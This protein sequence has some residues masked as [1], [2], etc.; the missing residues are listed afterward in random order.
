M[1]NGQWSLSGA[2]HKKP[3][4]KL[5]LA[6]TLPGILLTGLFIAL[7]VGLCLWRPGLAGKRPTV[8]WA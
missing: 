7:I 4:P 6:A 3:V 2:H 1:A 8:S 5:Y